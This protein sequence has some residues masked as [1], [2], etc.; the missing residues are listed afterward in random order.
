M[1]H[2]EE[3]NASEHTRALSPLTLSNTSDISDNG[4]PQ[5]TLLTML[6]IIKDDV[7]FLAGVIDPFDEAIEESPYPKHD[8]VTSSY[9]KKV[10][11]DEATSGEQD[12]ILDE[13]TSWP[14]DLLAQ[15]STE[16]TFEESRIR[17]HDSVP[18]AELE[19]STLRY[20]NVSSSSSLQSLP[21]FFNSTHK[22][23][24]REETMENDFK[25][26]PQPKVAK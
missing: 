14:E 20:K 15:D 10:N 13:L 11:L 9:T 8:V 6:D 21:T 26:V 17:D 12:I 23:A 18:S 2:A 24:A 16:V 4:L 5:E 7:Y 3:R 22:R 19:E 1:L 25:Q